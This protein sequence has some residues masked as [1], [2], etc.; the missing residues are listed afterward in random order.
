MACS[1]C[2]RFS[3]EVFQGGCGLAVLVAEHLFSFFSS[4]R[5]T[6]HRRPEPA[7]VRAVPVLLFGRRA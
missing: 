6:D 1:L 4:G 5:P 7:T 2:D 3:R